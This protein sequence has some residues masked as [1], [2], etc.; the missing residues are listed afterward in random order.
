[1]E[2]RLH[3]DLASVPALVPAWTELAAGQLFRSPDWLLPWWDQYGSRG[4]PNR[5]LA[6]VEV[7]DTATLALLPAWSE[8][9][10]RRVRFEL[11]GSGEVCSDHL[12][13]LVR[14]DLEAGVRREL[15]QRLA[16][17]IR[18]EFAELEGGPVRWREFEFDG[19]D[20]ADQATATFLDDLRT[21]GMITLPRSVP[22]AW[23]IDLPESWEAFLERLSKGHR[24]QVRR[25]ERT[26]NDSGRA[27][28][29]TVR[30]PE[31]LPRGLEIL[32]DLHQRR[33]RSLG[34]P[35]RFASE[36]FRN[37]IFAV[38]ERLLRAGALRLGWL[39]LD[40][41][42]AAVEFHARAGETIFAYQ[43][44]LDPERLDDEPGRLAFVAVLRE[45]IAEGV[46]T[47]D[48]LRGDEPYKSHWR[49]RP[50]PL[51]RWQVL[52]GGAGDQVRAACRRFR[53]AARR[54]L[55]RAPASA[56]LVGDVPAP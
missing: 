27:V 26:L 31:E 46:R 1:M 6:L 48:L 33:R 18:T 34:E 45:A 19:V 25:L 11:L 49:A 21:A 40:G 42:P 29:R 30:S 17:A 32:V 5:R 10:G 47:F 24:K 36:L 55:G 56:E 16:R 41:S 3:T 44:G 7:R 13:V 23:R 2:L 28:W 37:F 51:V 9:R 38:A 14:R 4:G 39:E 52:P 54:L 12:G 53:D 50:E 15:S 22:A 20:R 35:G 8:P 43:S